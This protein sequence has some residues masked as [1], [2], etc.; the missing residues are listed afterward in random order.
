[1]A[2]GKIKYASRTTLK[3]LSR[4]EVEQRVEH[5]CIELPPVSPEMPVWFNDEY[6]SLLDDPLTPE[7]FDAQH[8]ARQEQWLEDH[9]EGQ[10][11]PAAREALFRHG[12]RN[13]IERAGLDVLDESI[14][15]RLM[16][17]NR[18]PAG[19]DLWTHWKR[20]IATRLEREDAVFN[21][22]EGDDRREKS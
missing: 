6:D 22:L 17:K 4:A 19:C 2:K 20:R 16:N 15:S 18:V 21:V 13:A 12:L 8:K 11:H 1:M 7:H 10:E 5:A 14:T 9:K 3:R